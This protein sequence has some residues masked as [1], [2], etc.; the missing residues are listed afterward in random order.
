MSTSSPAVA[1]SEVPA[2]A[3]R[4]AVEGMKEGS[5]Q[6]RGSIALTLAGEADH[7]SESDKNL[8]KFHGSYQ[9][10]DRDAR[11]NRKKDG[12]G[13]HYM[14]MVRC[15][16]PGG[17][18]TAAQYLAVDELAEKHANGTLRLTTR[19]GIQLHG[20]LIRD[21]K[22]TIAGINQC[23]LTTLGACGDVERNVMA[24]PAPLCDHGVHAQL[25]ETAKTIACHLAPRTRAYHEIW[26]NGQ[27]IG[28]ATDEAE[29]EPLYG[30]TYLPRKFKTGLALPDDNCIDIHAQD[31]GLLAIVE[32]GKIVGYNVL[33]G[34]GMGMTHGN[35][36]TF[37]HLAVP[38]CYVPASAVVPTA[39][40]VVRL[41]RDHGN[42]ADRK[43]A[44]IKYLVH[45]WG[46]ER[47]REV[48]TEYVGGTLHLPK[49]VTVRGFETHTGWHEQGDGKF[50]YGV[51]IENGRI[52]DEGTFRLRTAL[53]TLISRLQPEL[54]I[55]PLQDLLLCNLKA[56]DRAD[57]ERTLR[58]HGVRL[59]EEFSAVRKHSMACPA[60]PTCGLAISES[61]RTL[62]ALIDQLDA[63][64]QRLGLQD[65]K[66]SV[67]MTGCPNGCARPYQSDIGIVGRSGDKYT[68]FVGGHVLGHRLNFQL[69]DLVPHAEIVPTLVPLLEHFKAD[70]QPGENFGD[71]CHRQGAERLQALLP[72]DKPAPHAP[73]SRLPHPEVNGTG[74]NGSAGTNGSVNGDHHKTAAPATVPPLKLEVPP[75]TVAPRSETFYVGQPG[76]EIRDYSYRYHT[77]GSVADTIIYFYGEGRRAAVSHAATPLRRE[78]VYL[79]RVEPNR[80]HAARKRSDTWYVGEP[81]RERPDRTVEYNADG[82]PLQTLVYFYE[83][84]LRAK[85][86]PSSVP[87]RRQVLHAG[88]AEG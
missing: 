11:K 5:R 38:I 68:L 84:D 26:L 85:D 87:L 43:R 88:V 19:Q 34:G 29:T 44:R 81:G 37:P 53:R 48:L 27:P 17:R 16:I 24:C 10:E 49:P 75:Q 1:P 66:L 9:Q 15:R 51:S 31:L 2:P 59:P 64:L 58:E 41:F 28:S 76:E 42:R 25:Q 13:K 86:A 18:L 21:L 22:A 47:F 14:F 83:G 30:K 50:F 36:N 60:I 79:G 61:E 40:A 72:G 33:V 55:T 80:L 52:K 57:I 45:D 71:F 3:K 20:V 69:K 63:A 32:A 65:E 54:R 39:E 77:D 74:T 62:P 70:R 6:L 82:Q 8:I 67:R 7:F 56:E 35:A 46:V 12:L 23:L 73:V 4:S 78:A